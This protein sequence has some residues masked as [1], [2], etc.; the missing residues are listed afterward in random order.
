MLMKNQNSCPKGKFIL[1][2]FKDVPDVFFPEDIEEQLCLNM[3]ID[4]PVIAI[5]KAFLDF[6]PK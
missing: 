6:I 5:F 2:H 1:E 4:N 3:E